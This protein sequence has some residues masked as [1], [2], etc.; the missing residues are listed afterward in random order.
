VASERG[1]LEQLIGK[2]VSDLKIIGTEFDPKPNGILGALLALIVAGVGSMMTATLIGVAS[3]PAGLVLAVEILVGGL[4]N[5]TVEFVYHFFLPLQIVSS[6]TLGG[7][8]ESPEL[9]ISAGGPLIQSAGLLGL[10]AA[11]IAFGA[12]LY[13]VSTV[14]RL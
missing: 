12:A 13:V 4:R 9:T 3:I 8:C 14:V 11:T 10:L 7:A 1:V 5:F 6:C 2:S